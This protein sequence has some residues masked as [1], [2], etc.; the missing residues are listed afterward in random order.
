GDT[1]PGV[2]ARLIRTL[3]EIAADT[4]PFELS[5]G[6][7]GALGKRVLSVKI[8]PD[9]P[10]LFSLVQ[11]I[12]DVCEPLGFK[13]EVRRYHPHLT[14]ARI[15]D[16]RRAAPLVRTFQDTAIPRV[17]SEVKRLTLYESRLTPTGSVYT[18]AASFPFE[19]DR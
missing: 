11:R 17:R 1:E 3:G 4:P 6:G 16:P 14:V 13:R 5:L 9:G 7:P 8:D 18:E 19:G 12:E 15:G 10:T 2:E